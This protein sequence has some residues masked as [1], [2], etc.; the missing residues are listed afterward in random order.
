MTNKTSLALCSALFCFLAIF[1]SCSKTN[2]NQPSEDNLQV[3][4]GAT[5]VSID[6]V[7]SAYVILKKVGTTDSIKKPLQKNVNKLVASV[8]NL[9]TGNYSAS[10]VLY[11]TQPDASLRKY[12]LMQTHSLPGNNTLSVN[13]P[14]GKI[15]DTWQTWIVQKQKGITLTIPLNFANPYF[16][17]ET[18]SNQWNYVYTDRIAYHVMGGT[19]NRL[20]SQTWECGNTTTNPCF[21][22]GRIGNSNGF[23]SFAAQLQNQVWN[24]GEFV[25]I[26][27]NSATGEEALFAYTFH[28]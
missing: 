8:A 22:Q 18:N 15:S 20:A 16:E 1:S 21:Q 27:M 2:Q 3:A 10:Y 6:A 14:T 7:D 9:A 11:S 17:I 4:F 23:Q 13:G 25:T 19:E 24:K 26:V 5:T 12:T 28:L